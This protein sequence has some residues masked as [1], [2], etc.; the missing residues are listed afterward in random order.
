MITSDKQILP[1]SLALFVG[2][3]SFQLYCL[4]GFIYE[5]LWSF[6]F[7]KRGLLLGEICSSEENMSKVHYI[8]DF[9]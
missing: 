5:K 1:P 7:S 6:T 2:G 9:W 8:I 4:W 3:Y